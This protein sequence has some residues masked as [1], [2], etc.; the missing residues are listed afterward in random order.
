M[1]V[2]F[3]ARPMVQTRGSIRVWVTKKQKKSL[4]VKAKTC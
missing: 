4:V 2:I 1:S 3:R